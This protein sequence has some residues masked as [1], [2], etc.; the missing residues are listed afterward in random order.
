MEKDLEGPDAILN[1]KGIRLDT[2]WTSSSTSC[3]GNVHLTF[4]C[5]TKHGFTETPDLTGEFTVLKTEKKRDCYI[6]TIK[7]DKEPE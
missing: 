1:L 6:L 5:H 7:F 3:G 2:R 4:E